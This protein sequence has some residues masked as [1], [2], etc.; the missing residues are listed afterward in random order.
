MLQAGEEL[1][2]FYLR[3]GFDE[4]DSGKEELSPAEGIMELALPSSLDAAVCMA[5][6]SSDIKGVSCFGRLGAWCSGHPFM[7]LKYKNS[8]RV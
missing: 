5:F 6:C 4:T 3:M 1:L 2:Q 7:D 8:A